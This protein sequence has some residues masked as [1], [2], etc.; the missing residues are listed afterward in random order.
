MKYRPPRSSPWHS[1]HAR[2]LSRRRPSVRLA[3]SAVAVMS[4]F[5]TSYVFF[6]RPLKAIRTYTTTQPAATS[7]PARINARIFSVFFIGRAW[8]GK[9]QATNHSRRRTISLPGARRQLEAW[10]AGTPVIR[11]TRAM[12]E[13][14]RHDVRFALRMLWRSPAF[15]ITA[16]VTLALGI[17]ANSAI[18]S[19][20]S[21]VLLRPLPYPAAGELA[22]V[23][24]DNARISLRED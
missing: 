6:Q 3:S 13:A 19:V 10:L 18:F 12:L 1:V 11:S 23:W 21:G 5:G 16:I 7:K 2:A 20:A 24:M 4:C 22:M 14:L 17:G 9:L 15:S 8:G